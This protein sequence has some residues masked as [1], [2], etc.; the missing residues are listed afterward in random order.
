[1]GAHVSFSLFDGNRRKGHEQREEAKLEQL[2]LASR[3]LQLR[4]GREVRTALADLASARSRVES[5]RESVAESERVLRDERIKF[6]AGRGV[7]N[8]VLDAESALLTSQSLLSQAER[9]VS[10]AA[11][12]LDLSVGRI[13]AGRLPGGK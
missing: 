12:A 13:D 5:L 9:S 3:Q 4:T 1:M 11:L 10:I 7:I 2:R 6:E 8:F